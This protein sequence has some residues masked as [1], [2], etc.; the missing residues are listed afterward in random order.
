VCDV[1]NISEES[2]K[3]PTPNPN[4]LIEL[5]YALKALGSNR[6]LMVLNEAF[7]D[8]G[9]LPFDLRPRRLVLYHMPEGDADRA[10]VRKQLEGKLIADLRTILS[11]ANTPLPGEVIELTA[12][13]QVR[14]AVEGNRP[15]QAGLMRQYMAKLTHDIDGHS[16]KLSGV[17]EDQW[18]ELLLKSLTESLETVVEFTRVSQAVA[19][20]NAADAAKALYKGFENVLN[21]Y[22]LP[23]DFKGQFNPHDFDFAEFVGYELFVTVFACLIQEQRWELIAE[24]L[25]QTF[26]VKQH[27]RGNRTRT[28]FTF[29]SERVKLLD[30]RKQRL[31]SNRVSLR[32]DLLNERHTQGELGELMPIQ[33]FVD[34]DYFLFLRSDLPPETTHRGIDWK[35]WSLLYLNEVPR[36]L[37]DATSARVAEQLFR[38]FRVNDIATFRSRLDERK[39]RYGQLWSSEAIWFSPLDGFDTDVIGSE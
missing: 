32:A 37:V 8:K 4:V 36:F 3:R 15:N 39:L 5:G 30:M 6:I 13:E 10:S 20:A 24:L 28:L 1:S 9:F 22:T 35:P 38:P 16:L 12:A 29:V 26:Y 34:A 7:G 31:K 2:A 19:I 27:D 23:N 21:L 11:G 25:D 18:D 33:Q 14:A 17:P